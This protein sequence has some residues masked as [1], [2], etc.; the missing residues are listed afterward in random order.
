MEQKKSKW[1]V[2]GGLCGLL[3]WLGTV[4]YG[5]NAR[6]AWQLL[7]NAFQA[8]G[9][10]EP[11]REGPLHTFVRGR[12][13]L[14][15]NPSPTVR[16]VNPLAGGIFQGRLVADIANWE[17]NPSKAVSAGT[18]F[19]NGY[20]EQN[21]GHT[22]VWVFD[23]LGGQVRFTGASGLLRNAGTGLYESAPFSLLAGVYKACVQLQNHDHTAAIPATAP[24]FPGIDCVTFRVEGLGEYSYGGL[25]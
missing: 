9:E 17:V 20:Q 22:H 24:S 3:V 21:T 14:K 2:A 15:H 25:R 12:S 8:M 18:Q 5:S 13:V 4:A 7:E 19:A 23:D 16:F 6:S 10:L 1:Y 11:F